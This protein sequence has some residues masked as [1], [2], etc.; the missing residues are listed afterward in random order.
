M[1][2]LRVR[3]PFGDSALVIPIQVPELAEVREY[4][5]VLHLRGEAYEGQMWGWAVHY[6]PELIEENAL[7]ALPDENNGTRRERRKHFSPA[8]FTVGESGIWFFS[9]LWENGRD[10][11]PVEFLDVVSVEAASFGVASS[12]AVATS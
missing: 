11:E 5:N 8:S 7:F 6:E 4:A 12:A 3:I 10:A 2:T 1:K 9:L